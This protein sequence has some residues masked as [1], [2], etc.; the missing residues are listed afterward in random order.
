MSESPLTI[1]IKATVDKSITG[2]PVN[3]T[4]LPGNNPY[5]VQHIKIMEVV[6]SVRIGHDAE[7]TQRYG[8]H[9]EVWLSPEQFMLLMK[10]G[11]ENRADLEKGSFVL[12][13]DDV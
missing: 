2:V 9:D 12:G 3:E 7:F 10:W 11:E 13:K 5:V 6:N 1:N 8:S 4:A